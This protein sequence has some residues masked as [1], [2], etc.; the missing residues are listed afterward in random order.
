MFE[1]RVLGRIFGPNRD[2]ITGSWTKLY[3]EEL[4]NLYSSPNVIKMIKSRRM[5]WAGHVASTDRRKMHERFW[6]ENQK[7]R[8][9]PLGK[10]RCRWENIKMDFRK[11][12]WG[13]MNCIH[14]AQDRDKWRVL[15]N[16][17]RNLRVP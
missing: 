5:R 17:T 2:K 11:I 9:Q 1:N 12:G 14:L 13:G 8:D 6:W 10:V 7:E 15:V 16:I 3:N 4:H